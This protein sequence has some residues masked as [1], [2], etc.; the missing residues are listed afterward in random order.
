MS[1]RAAAEK[2]P[3]PTNKLDLG[4][5]LGA[6][7]TPTSPHPINE[8]YVFQLLFLY[9]LLSVLLHCKPKLLCF[10]ARLCNAAFWGFWILV[11]WIIR[12]CQG[13]V[14]QGKLGS[15]VD[16]LDISG[17]RVEGKTKGLVSPQRRFDILFSSSYVFLAGDMGFSKR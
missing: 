16:V 15:S 7:L 9:S 13:F 1:E 2:D 17:G 11:S 6:G 4:V 14:I 3:C 10:L 8:S 5:V 12:G